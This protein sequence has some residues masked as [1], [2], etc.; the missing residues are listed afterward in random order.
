MVKA[1]IMVIMTTT[2]MRLKTTMRMKTVMSV[3]LL[4]M[5][6]MMMIVM[7]IDD[8][9][10]L[11]HDHLSLHFCC[12][13]IRYDSISFEAIDGLSMIA[14]DY[15]TEAMLET[16]GLKQRLGKTYSNGILQSVLLPIAYLSTCMLQ[17]H[18]DART[19][20]PRE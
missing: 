13:G 15:L 14:K 18:D 10:Y 5:I 9:D 3:M 6:M 11:Q 4:K 12:L 17:R 16:P 7:M 20:S 1:V 8:R 2:E 19:T